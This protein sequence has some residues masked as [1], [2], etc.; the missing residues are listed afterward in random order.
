MVVVSLG[1]LEVFPPNSELLGLQY[2]LGFVWFFFFVK[3]PK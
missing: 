2:G 1:C 3:L